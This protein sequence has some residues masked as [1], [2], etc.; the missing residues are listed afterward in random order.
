MTNFRFLPLNSINTSFNTVKFSSKRE[1]S[2]QLKESCPINEFLRKTA[3][4]QIKYSTYYHVY[5]LDE[6]GVTKIFRLSPSIVNRIRQK[7]TE[8]KVVWYKK[9]ISEIYS[10]LRRIWG[11]ITKFTRR[12]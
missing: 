4:D 10:F 5:G 3:K 7:I 8:V 1:Y 11:F 9:L 6:S 2:S 12:T